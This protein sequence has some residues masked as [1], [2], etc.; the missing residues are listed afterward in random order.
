MTVRAREGCSTRASTYCDAALHTPSVWRKRAWP[1]FPGGHGTPV[2]SGSRGNLR[3]WASQLSR[4]GG[5]HMGSKH[6]PSATH[7]PALPIPSLRAPLENTYCLPHVGNPGFI[8]KVRSLTRTSFKSYDLYK[9]LRN[10]KNSF[11]IPPRGW[12]E[13]GCGLQREEGLHEF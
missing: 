11:L 5:G 1:R 4:G 10:Y 13:G 6:C 7:G 2:Q 3:H 12:G 8:R 9:M